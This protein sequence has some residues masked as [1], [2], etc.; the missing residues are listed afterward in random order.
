MY[1]FRFKVG[2]TIPKEVDIIN[3]G[4]PIGEASRCHLYIQGKEVAKGFGSFL[5][6][7]EV[8]H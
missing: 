5:Q 2:T 7:K 3:K 6:I 4:Y 1:P 8:L